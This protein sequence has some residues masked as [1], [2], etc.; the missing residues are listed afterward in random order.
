LPSGATGRTITQE[1]IVEQNTITAQMEAAE[2]DRWVTRAQAGELAGVD[3]KT[4]DRWANDGHIDRYKLGGLQWVRF[5]REQ[6]LAM[7]RP[8][9]EGPGTTTG[10]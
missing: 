3:P 9:A 2:P 5:D 4:V 8:V 10:E 1:A 6:V 7:R